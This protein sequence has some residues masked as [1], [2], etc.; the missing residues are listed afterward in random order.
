V[1]YFGHPLYTFVG[2][3]VTGDANGHEV[4]AFGGTWYALKAN[5]QDA[6]G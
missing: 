3:K 5:G 1:T 4:E 6:P 2:D